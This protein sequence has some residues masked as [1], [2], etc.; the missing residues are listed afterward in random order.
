MTNNDLYKETKILASYLKEKKEHLYTEIIRTENFYSK[1]FII[2]KKESLNIV[3]RIYNIRVD[4]YIEIY[5]NCIK[6][7]YKNNN[8]L[9]NIENNIENNNNLITYNSIVNKIY[10]YV[11]EANKNN[12]IK[13]KY[14]NIKDF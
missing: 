7:K 5:D 13:I 14:L 4:F 10:S 12:P 9:N 8:D 3:I 1:Y 6:L 2:E 11:E